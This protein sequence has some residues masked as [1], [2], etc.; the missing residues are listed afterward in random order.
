MVKLVHVG[1]LDAAFACAEVIPE[2]QRRE[3]QVIIAVKSS[4]VL[5]DKP[6]ELCDVFPL[7]CSKS[8][9]R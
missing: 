7:H 3:T 2:P 4:C 1:L 9:H 8:Q 5:Y 6:T